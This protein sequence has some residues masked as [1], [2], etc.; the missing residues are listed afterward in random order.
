MQKGGSKR[1]RLFSVE[2]IPLVVGCLALEVLRGVRR[3]ELQSSRRPMVRRG[4]E[5]WRSWRI[6]TINLTLPGPERQPCSAFT[7]LYSH[8]SGPNTLRLGRKLCFLDH[9]LLTPQFGRVLPGED[10][11]RG[12]LVWRTVKQARSGACPALRP[13]PR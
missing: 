4:Q 10:G 6:A 8:S 11:L 13:A 1:N 5:R 7:V 2:W 9:V 12:G 3:H